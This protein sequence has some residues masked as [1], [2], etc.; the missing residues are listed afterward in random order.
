MVMYLLITYRMDKD[1]FD[2]QHLVISNEKF[3]VKLDFKRDSDMMESTCNNRIQ[4]CD[5]NR[6]ASALSIKSI[7]NSTVEKEC[8]ISG[9]D[10]AVYLHQSGAKENSQSVKLDGDDLIMSLGFTL[11]SINLKSMQSN[12]I[13]RPDPAEIF[14]FYDLEDDILLRGELQIHRIDKKGKIKWSYGGMD[15]WVNIDGKKEVQIDKNTIRLVDFCAN[16][17]VIDFD[18]KTLSHKPNDNTS[19]TKKRTFVD[20]KIDN[21]ASLPFIVLGVAL[22][23]GGLFIIPVKPLP[24]IALII[25]GLVLS[26]TH[27]R[28]EVNLKEKSYREYVRVLGIKWGSKIKF[29]EVRYFY[30][31]KSKVNQIY[32]QTYKN[33]YVTVTRFNG[34]LKF[35]ED[36][37]IAIGNS[38]SKDSLLKKI[39]KV[40]ANLG[41]EIKDFS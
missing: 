40:N 17:Y 41:L 6:R 23:I 33:H 18:G 22:I 5:A 36:E 34:Y 39:K 10:G 11:I 21:W 13:F 31:T 32:G 26:T 1:F 24:A 4:I 2:D 19:V 29:D 15:I 28:L 12:W 25:A 3:V 8:L 20:F 35:N 30:L 16:E 27:N 7:E 37:K 38:Q 9:I 14:E